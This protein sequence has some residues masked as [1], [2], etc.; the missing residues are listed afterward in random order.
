MK[1]MESKAT[2]W[3]AMVMVVAMVV[4]SMLLRTP[5]YGL[6]AEFLCFLGVFSH[7]SSL[8]LRK[9]SYPASR[10]LDT[11]ALVFILLSLA[12]FLVEYIIYTISR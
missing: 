11:F 6:I 9:M 4:L 12:A 5:W 2:A 10:K 7:L 3:V 1:L 8:Y